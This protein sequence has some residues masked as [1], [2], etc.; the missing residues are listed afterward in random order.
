MG[1]HHLILAISLLLCLSS[2]TVTAQVVNDIFDMTGKP[3]EVG[4]PYYILPVIQRRG[5][6]ITTAPKNVNQ[7]CPLYVAQD[8][9]TASLGLPVKFY[10]PRWPV[11][12]SRPTKNVTFSTDMNLFFGLGNNCGQSPVWTLK[13]DE[14]TQRQYVTLGGVAGYRGPKTVDNWFRIERFFPRFNFDYKLVYCP[15]VCS[16]ENPHCQF[17]C[18]DLGVFIQEDG[19]WLLGVG[20]PPLRIKFK[21]A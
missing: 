2:F 13:L 16:S 9:N 3:V 15:T 7:Q 20:A 5:G 18:G 1:T 11:Y 12:S 17:S 6:G 10:P 21:R 19:N 4:V 8:T 14:I